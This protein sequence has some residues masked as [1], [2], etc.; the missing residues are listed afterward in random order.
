MIYSVQQIKHDILSYT[1]EFGGDFF[2]YYVGI[3]ENPEEALFE[4]HK[5][6]RENDPW[7]YRQTVSSIAA[8]TVQDYFF[9]RLKVDAEPAFDRSDQPNFVYAYKK[10]EGTVP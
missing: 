10:S 7:L 1:K 3:T 8:R 2:D 6:D 4:T 5:V 9:N